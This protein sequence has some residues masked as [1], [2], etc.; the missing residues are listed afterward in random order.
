MNNIVRECK[1]RITRLEAFLPI[2]EMLYE[3][4]KN[5]NVKVTM[6]P[7]R[8]DFDNPKRED[9]YVIMQGLSA[10]KWKREPIEDKMIYSTVIDGLTYYIWGAPPPPSCEI[11]EEEE[12]VPAQPEQWI[13]RRRVVCKGEDKI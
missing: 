10:G 6:W 5:L 11:I 12:L 9:V 1:D 7:D 4:F 13:K 2:A 8:V 3:K